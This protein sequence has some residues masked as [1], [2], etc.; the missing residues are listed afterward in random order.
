MRKIKVSPSL[1]SANFASL[2]EDLM[3]V[4]SCCEMIHLDVMD[5]SFVPNISFGIPVI[6]SI[7]NA[8]NLFFDTHLMITHPK[9]YIHEF[10]IS[11]SDSITFHLE[12]CNDLEEVIE[13]IELIK[14]ENKKVGISIKPNTPVETI[15]SLLLRE[16][17]DLVLIMSV[18]PGFGGQKFM[19][20]SLPKIRELRKF[21]D[22][23]KLNTLIEVDG[24][25]QSETAALV[26]EAGVDILV[27][28]SYLFNSENFAKSVESICQE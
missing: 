21:I 5:G 12:A 1:L 23:N 17:I 20:N 7:R 26:I 8:T 3:K 4:E 24:G 27:S 16:D 9:K 19:K 10:A 13:T 15:Y 14:K 25:I 22:E 6:K 18:E 28:G 2:K 11:G